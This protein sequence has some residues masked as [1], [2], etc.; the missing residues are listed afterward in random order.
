MVFLVD[1][2]RMKTI[3]IPSMLNNKAL[4]PFVELR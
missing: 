4:V 3:D 2:G 1:D